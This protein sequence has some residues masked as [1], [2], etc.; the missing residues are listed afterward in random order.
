MSKKL[1]SILLVMI[2]GIVLVF[3]SCGGNGDTNTDT[4]TKT[5][6]ET[7]TETN[8]DTE[9]TTETE[10]ETETEAKEFIYTVYV[11]NQLGQPVE[12]VNLQICNDSFCL[13]SKITDA[14][15]VAKF[16]IDFEDKFKVQIN[17]V[18]KEGGYI[19]PEVNKIPFE[20]GKSTMVVI[21]EQNETYVVTA[22]DLHGKNLSGILVELLD[23]SKNVVGSIVTKEN[24]VAEFVVAPG[25]YYA[26]ASHS[27]GNGAYKLITIDEEGLVNFKDT[28]TKQIQFTVVDTP[29]DY[30][31]NVEGAKSDVKV[32]LYN[33]ELDLVDEKTT[34]NGVAKFQAPNGDYFAVLDSALGTY[35]NYVEFSK[36]GKTTG[37]MTVSADKAGSKDTPIFLVGD[38]NVTLAKGESVWYFIPNSNGKV[39]EIESATASIIYN[40]LPKNP[41]DGK[42][43]V[44]LKSG[45]AVKLSTTAEAGE[46][47][48][49][50]VYLPGS[51]KTPY[52]INESAIGEG[53]K[54]TADVVENGAVYYSFVASK[55]GTVRVSNTTENAYITINGNPNKKSVKAGDTVVICLATQ[56][57]AEG[58]IERPAASIEATLTFAKTNANYNV[59]VILDNEP[60]KNA[61]LQLYKL[62][63]E[64]YVVCGEGTVVCDANG[65][66]TFTGLEERADYYIKVTC[67]DGYETEKEYIPFGDETDITIYVNHER[68]GSLEYPFLVN[69]DENTSSTTEITVETGKK[70]YYTIFYIAGATISIDNKDA[71]VE[72]IVNSKTEA[73]LTG[74]TLS[75][76]LVSSSGSESSNGTTTRVLILVSMADETASGTVNLTITAPEIK[77]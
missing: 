22:A 15:G 12:G 35:A 32:M 64:S 68:D 23:E 27:E 31:V 2:L 30:T 67:P 37:E 26:R 28:K 43:K 33:K 8:T 48:T 44:D 19:M 72:I 42:I 20:D 3:A 50:K 38:I 11:E 75:Y 39:I 14:E 34:S 51:Q 70:V 47:I 76:Q 17:S 6:T 54:L 4:D 52:E 69:G 36:D 61:E 71:K 66:Y 60:L 65:K 10:T 1:L 25:T 74:E 24:G 73:I 77:E 21:I 63:N 40:G 5:D 55:D 46:T 49:G 45:A 16:T 7:N 41:I 56:K 9:T 62:E 13:T 57:G 58:N 29:I 59:T 18:P 53:Y